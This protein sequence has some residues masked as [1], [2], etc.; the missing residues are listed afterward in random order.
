[1]M[2]L[3]VENKQYKDV[4]TNCKLWYARFRKDIP[5]FKNPIWNNYTFWQFSSEINCKKTGECLYN[6]PGTRYDMDV[7][8]YNGSRAELLSQW[9]F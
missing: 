7:N 5:D 9:P 8:I 2:N 3:I 1:M 4:F 6:L